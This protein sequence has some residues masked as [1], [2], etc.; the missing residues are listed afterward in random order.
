VPRANRLWW[1]QKIAG[2][3][4]RDARKEKILRSQGFRVCLVWQCEIADEVRLGKRLV[5]F[6]KELGPPTKEEVHAMRGSVRQRIV[7]SP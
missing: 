3:R 2:N 7:A 1:R 6:L 4:I 5:Q